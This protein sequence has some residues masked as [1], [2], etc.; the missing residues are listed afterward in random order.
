M[1]TLAMIFGML[2]VAASIGAG[3]F[4]HAKDPIT[5]VMTKDIIDIF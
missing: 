1:T 2:P 3:I 4:S 5:H